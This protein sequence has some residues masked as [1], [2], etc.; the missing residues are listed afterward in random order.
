MGCGNVD[1]NSVSSQLVVGWEK[2]PVEL[3]LE[4]LVEVEVDERVVD[5]GAFGE[6]G[7]KHETLRSHVPVLLVENEKEGHDSVGSPGNYKTQTD[8]EK[9]LEGEATE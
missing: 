2:Q 8:A 4:S 5:V 6:E 3:P 7:G 9:H 1:P